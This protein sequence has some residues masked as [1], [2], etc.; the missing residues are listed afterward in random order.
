M[1]SC[2]ISTDLPTTNRMRHFLIHNR[3]KWTWLYLIWSHLCQKHL[4]SAT[5]TTHVT[6]LTYFLRVFSH[7]PNPLDLTSHPEPH[8]TFVP[9]SFGSSD[10]FLINPLCP[11]EL[12]LWEIPHFAPFGS[13]TK[14]TNNKANWTDFFLLFNGT[15]TLS[16]LLILQ[17]CFLKL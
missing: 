16:P 2:D 15:S 14:P 3:L 1:S 4:P 17:K 10:Y 13:L 7:N 9:S 12:Q 8:Q 5:L 11:I 6:E